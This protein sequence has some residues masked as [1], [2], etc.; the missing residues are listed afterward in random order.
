MP[1]IMQ[2]KHP[3]LMFMIDVPEIASPVLK[4]AKAE[5]ETPMS[6]ARILAVSL[7]WDIK[8]SDGVSSPLY[9]V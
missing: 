3:K 6:E 2:R 1:K 5:G 9:N 8:A 4:W 7:A